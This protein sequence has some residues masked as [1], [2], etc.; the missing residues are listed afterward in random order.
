MVDHDL[1][2][3]AASIPMTLPTNL[4]P[5]LTLLATAPA[6]P[7]T[8]ATSGAPGTG[9][10]NGAP[11]G[12]GGQPDPFGGLLPILMIG[13]V[14]MLVLSVMGP[15]REKKRREALMNS[16][17]KHDR[18]QTIGGV[19]GSIV[20]LKPDFVTLKVDESSNTRI[21]VART[22]IAQVLEARGARKAES[23]EAADPANA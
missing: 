13:M 17:Q 12:A 15:R 7:P 2:T 22:A 3:P 16:L 21:T 6:G 20:E 23:A 1:T 14:V 9:A 11:G 4:D 19:V 8:G 10:P 18:V 5:S